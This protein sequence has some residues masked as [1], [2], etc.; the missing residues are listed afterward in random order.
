MT[1]MQVMNIEDNAMTP[2]KI[3]AQV[4]TIQKVMKQVMKL[5]EHYGTIPGCGPKPTLLKPGAEK[6]CVTFRLAPSY[7]I[8]R[9][10]MGDDHR[11][12][13]IVCTLTHMTS[14]MVVGQ[15]VGTCSTKEGKF[16]YR[17]T[18]RKCPACE[19]ETII[20]GKAEY[21]GGWLCWAKKGGC[22]AK[23]KEG[24]TAIEGQEAG[25]AEHDNPPDYYNTVLKMAKKRALVD[26]AL[27]AT[28]ASDLFTQDIE[29]MG[30]IL[31]PMEKAKEPPPKNQH[32]YRP[33]DEEPPVKHFPHN[34]TTTDPGF[35]PN[36]PEATS[37]QMN[38]LYKMTEK[39]GLTNRELDEISNWY[40]KG[41]KLSSAEAGE[42]IGDLPGIMERYMDY[43]ETLKK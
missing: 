28:A 12:Y 37:P 9:I 34:T 39:Q 13:Q 16:R 11:E 30:E 25:K 2:E 22:G 14:G 17:T 15:G 21:G 42:M 3:Q 43:L 1:E 10:D 31:P 38:A 7:D 33:P 41:D 24:D 5:G 36:G 4:N 18:E 6:L 23:F 35:P 8:T 19:K 40:K 29:D 26:A 27:T 20:K 32:T